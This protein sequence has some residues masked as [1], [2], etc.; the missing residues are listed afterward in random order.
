MKSWNNA[1]AKTRLK[2]LCEHSGLGYGAL[3]ADRQLT[4]TLTRNELLFPSGVLNL[5]RRVQF[6]AKHFHDPIRNGLCDLAYFPVD[7]LNGH[8]VAPA[9]RSIVVH[10]QVVSVFSHFW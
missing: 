8:T 6:F 7:E 5:L 2:S 4:V 1:R 9:M 3:E 10:D